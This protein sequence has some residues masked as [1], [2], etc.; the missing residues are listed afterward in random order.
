M[1]AWEKGGAFAPPAAP[2]PEITS[3]DQPLW[4]EVKHLL[5]DASEIIEAFRGKS[6]RGHVPPDRFIERIQLFIVGEGNPIRHDRRVADRGATQRANEAK[7][8]LREACAAIERAAEMFNSLDNRSRQLI[9]RAVPILLKDLELEGPLLRSVLDPTPIEKE[10][11]EIARKAL[12]CV[13][14]P[15][16]QA[17]GAKPRATA[18]ASVRVKVL[19]KVLRLCGVSNSEASPEAI[20]EWLRSR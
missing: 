5:P 12:R 19:S 10:W 7:E 20:R 9:H 2:A 14:D 3:A 1:T 6:G 13:V 15:A 11:R 17:A 18:A 8:K 16:V 4:D